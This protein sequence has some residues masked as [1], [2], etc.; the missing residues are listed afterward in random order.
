MTDIPL[1]EDEV[2]NE[3]TVVRRSRRIH[4]TSK[5]VCVPLP[6]APQPVDT[7]PD[8]PERD[9]DAYSDTEGANLLPATRSRAQKGSGRPVSV[10]LVFADRY[11][12]SHR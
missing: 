2:I 7:V 6:P 5:P 8:A 9:G 1:D 12:K 11:L 4:T 10:S 3:V